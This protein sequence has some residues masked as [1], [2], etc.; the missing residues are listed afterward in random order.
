VNINSAHEAQKNAVKG[1]GWIRKLYDWTL[2]WADT[3][4]GMTALVLLAFAESSFFP[5]PPDVLLIAIVAANSKHWLKAASLCSIASIAGVIL[6]FFIG[7]SFWFAVRDYFFAW[8]P[9]F[10][11]EHFHYVTNLY[12]EHAFF[13]VFTAAFSPI[14]FKIFTIAAGVVDAENNISL[15][16]FLSTSSCFIPLMAG[17]SLG[18]PTRFFLV[19]GLLRIFGPP[20]RT[21]IDKYFELLTIAF[22]ILLIGGFA[23][24][25]LIK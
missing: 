19:S 13:G 1:F 4:Y 5:I 17:A 16:M 21:F 11:P 23:V 22:T 6:G 25:S 8:I 9:G 7:Y 3:Q 10:T 15:K 20:I 18:R 24:L 2:H 14:P 12:H